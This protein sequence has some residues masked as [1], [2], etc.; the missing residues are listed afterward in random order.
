M[1]KYL[2]IALVSIINIISVFYLFQRNTQTVYS[3]EVVYNVSTDVNNELKIFLKSVA[4]EVDRVKELFN[5]D[6]HFSQKELDQ[7]FIQNSKLNPSLYSLFL[8]KNNLF[9]IVNRE[10][11]T[12]KSAFDTLGSFNIVKWNRFK[13]NEFV[14]SWTE[15]VQL[16]SVAIELLNTTK[17]LD[18][19]ILLWS[20]GDGIDTEGN[21]FL[22]CSVRMT[23]DNNEYVII[24]RFINSTLDIFNSKLLKS[25]E[26]TFILKK[27][28]NNY[29]KFTKDT[30]LNL[31][32]E[33]LTDSS[34][35]F[36]NKIIEY[37]KKLNKLNDSIFSFSYNDSL[38]WTINLNID[39]KYGI[40]YFTLTI[41]DSVIKDNSNNILILIVLYIIFL[42]ISVVLILYLLKI[43]KLKSHTVSYDANDVLLTLLK[44]EES[45][46][47]EFKSSLRWD[48]R[49]EKVNPDLENVILKTIAAFGNSDGGV[50]LIGVSD[51]KTIIGLDKDYSSLK[52]YGA[53]FFEIYLRNI[54]HKNMGVKYVTENLRIT[55]HKFDDKE[56]C[57]IEIFKAN[58][59][60]YLTINKK[61]NISEKFYV[62]SGNSSNE[63]SSLKDI[64]D[65]IFNRFKK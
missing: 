26:N 34:L 47:L 17:K 63:L 31:T 22:V 53:D 30:L 16:D 9:Y 43:I 25:N 64:N 60:L 55:F 15:V 29:I 21:N 19:D 59:P 50:L 20:V 51:D 5:S 49:Q 11:N 48:F 40:D 4:S 62:R 37:S 32:S 56:I 58:E 8:K 12:L 65:Y 23:I 41:P 3:E 39:A 35:S 52:K 61:G 2:F 13:D 46:Y 44:N 14:T 38:F 57:K 27:D 7:F 28:D 6:K 36:E 42:I 1:Q 18:N 45:R 54:L 33:S 24:F 10:E